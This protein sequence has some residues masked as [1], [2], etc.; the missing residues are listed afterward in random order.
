MYELIMVIANIKHWWNG[1]SFYRFNTIDELID[2]MTS[3][4]PMRE[5]DIEFIYS[6]DMKKDN[7][8]LAN[9]S[10]YRVHKGEY[11]MTEY[12]SF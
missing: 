11:E 9:T 10:W 7:G 6:N 5:R 8:N 12:T 1:K 4:I 2:F 3:H